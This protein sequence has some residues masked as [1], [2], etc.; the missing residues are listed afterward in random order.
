MTSVPLRMAVFLLPK[1]PW[2]GESKA[3][4]VVKIQATG[5]E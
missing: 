5:L 3:G 1:I 4:S 2:P